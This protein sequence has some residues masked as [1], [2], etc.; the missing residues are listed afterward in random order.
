MI[1]RDMSVQPDCFADRICILANAKK[2]S[3]S[4]HFVM[5]AKSGILPFVRPPFLPV[6]D[7][8]QAFRLSDKPFALTLKIGE[9]APCLPYPPGM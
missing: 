5:P 3:K 9:R 2:E 4:R 1:F 7:A 6:S 8:E